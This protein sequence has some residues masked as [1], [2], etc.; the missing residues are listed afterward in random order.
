MNKA[1]Y[2]AAMERAGGRCENHNCRDYFDESLEGRA[3]VDH[4]FGR[5]KADDTPENCWVLCWF[6]HESKGTSK[7]NAA[8][9]LRR[10]IEFCAKHHYA[11][12]EQ[13]AMKRLEWVHQKSAFVR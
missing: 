7:P 1:T 9:W 13:R 10:F 6:C 12:A 2:A 5:A 4:F 3:T 8:F 11:D